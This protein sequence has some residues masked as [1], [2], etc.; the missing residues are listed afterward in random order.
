MF[1]Q[2]YGNRENLKFP[3]ENMETENRVKLP[4]FQM[5]EKV[6]NRAYIYEVTSTADACRL[7]KGHLSL[8][9]PKQQHHSSAHAFIPKQ[10]SK[11]SENKVSSRG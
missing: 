1:K 10:K 11:K 4:I 2:K 5:E 8:P 6:E 3:L 7:W 9:F